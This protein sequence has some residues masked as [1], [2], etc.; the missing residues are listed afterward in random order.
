MEAHAHSL[1]VVAPHQH[2]T[3]HRRA[4]GLAGGLA[5]LVSLTGCLILPPPIPTAPPVAPPSV[6]PVAPPSVTPSSP[7]PTTSPVATPDPVVPP[8]EASGEA[9]TP[10]APIGALWGGNSSYSDSGL[11]PDSPSSLVIPPSTGTPVVAAG[12]PWGDDAAADTFRADEDPAAGT[13]LLL[14]TSG[15]IYMTFEDG[16]Q[17][18]CSA[19]VI[20]SAT[21][22]IAITAAHCLFNTYS[23]T[24]ATEVLFVPGDAGN[25]TEAPFGVWSAELWWMPQTFIDTAITADNVSQ[26]DG[27]AWD[28]GYLRF[29]PNASGQEIEQL[30]GGQGVSFRGET[31]SILMLGYPTAEPFDGTELRFCS[32]QSVGFGG[33]YWPHFVADCGMTPGNSG[34]AWITDVDPNTGAG[35]IVGVS[36]TI[37]GQT[38]SSSPLG[39]NALALLQE[40]EE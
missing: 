17:S 3:V 16:S 20:N 26:G 24:L 23:L 22:N 34:G 11:Q 30:T 7:P 21:D 38:W 14:S 40:I 31:N 39:Q 19:T 35:Y 27:W 4:A 15:R 18:T 12:S 13:D 37:L 33:M 2:R 10:D 1:Q 6:A 32:E 29:P 5:L 9:V 28:Y 36:S 25:G 8:E